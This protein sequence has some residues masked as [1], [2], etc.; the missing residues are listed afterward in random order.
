M[1][2]LGSY[3]LNIEAMEIL[4]SLSKEVK[5][6]ELSQLK[7][8]DK[9]IFN[10]FKKLI[11]DKRI[12]L[13]G[14]SIKG[15]QILGLLEF[16]NLSFDNVFIVGMKDSA[17]PAIKK[18]Y[19]LIPKDIMYALGIERV[20][21]EYEIQQYYFNRIIS[22]SKKL[23][24]IYPD[25]D[26]DE[27]SRF[28]ESIIWNKQS[29]NKDIN[30]VKINKFVLPRFSVNYSGKRKHAKTKEIKEYLKNM[31]YTYSKIDTYL[32]C[33]LKFYFRYVLL[34]DEGVKIR[35]ELSDGD[36]GNF[37]HDFLRGALYEN[38]N[39]VKLKSLEFEKEYFKKLENNF[40]NSP[41][42]KFREDA[43]MIKEILMHRMKN[44]LY[45]EKQ[46]SY[47]NIYSSE[48][49]YVSS[50]EAKF[51]DVYKLN[52]KIDR[53]DSNGK[54][55]M[56]FDY[57]TGII[58]DNIVRK[59]YLDLLSDFTRQNI[60]KAIKS[61]QLPLY[62]YIFEKESGLTVLECG[63]YDVKKAK[64]NIF[65]GDVEVYE[66]CIDVVRSLLNEINTGENFEF[67]N[68]D[69]VNCERCKYFYI[70]K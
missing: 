30:A 2:A 63:V 61:L 6:G 41:Y 62:K 27:R 70:C 33:R 44:I 69:K 8:Q 25:N 65:P 12:A 37:V 1:S 3:P 7:F 9:E 13:M 15:L 19:S 20:K 52:C 48:K 28:I 16:G 10:I 40:A 64:I 58:D 55:Y 14:S 22:G 46:R 67:D 38:L 66:K 50:I 35:Q 47:K 43:F 60:K 45:Y 11:K 17:I 26:K 21:K 42:F 51:G 18:D 53:I 56:V 24:L 59:K 57:K 29:E 23:N 32:N 34:L 4:L 36:I 39:S 31:H 68:E 49:K 5:Y 54:G